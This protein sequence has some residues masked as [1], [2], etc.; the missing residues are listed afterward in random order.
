LRGG[1]RSSNESNESVGWRGLR[2][3]GEMDQDL[4]ELRSHI[5]SDRF[6]SVCRESLR[7]LKLGPLP[8]PSRWRRALEVLVEV[9][10]GL[11]AGSQHLNLVFASSNIEKLFLS[12]Y[13]TGQHYG[14]VRE[15][16]QPY[17][18]WLASQSDRFLLRTLWDIYEPAEDAH[19]ETWRLW[20]RGLVESGRL[21]R[22]FGVESL[23]TGIELKHEGDRIYFWPKKRWPGWEWGRDISQYKVLLADESPVVRAASAFVAGRFYIGADRNL[24]ASSVPSLSEAL[25]WMESEEWRGTGV[26][27]AFLAGALFPMESP[28]W[29]AA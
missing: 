10:E 19:D 15:Q 7:K 21:A 23:K 25:T 13:A 12:A 27:G 26:A 8:K 4:V 24:G 18:T 9:F 28:L 14:L 5:A 29:A 2:D 16:M 6:S 22:C 3:I 1:P 11:P 17:L 20:H